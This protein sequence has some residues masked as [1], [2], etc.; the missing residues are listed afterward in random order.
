MGGANGPRECAPDDELHDTHQL[1]SCLDGFRKGLNPSH[2]L[3]A[4]QPLCAISAT[5]PALRL[6]ILGS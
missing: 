5:L 6:G 2:E 4:A 1:L 3:I